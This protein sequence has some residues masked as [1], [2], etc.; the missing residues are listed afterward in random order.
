MYGVYLITRRGRWERY[1]G[2]FRT[3]LDKSR[4]AAMMAS[5]S[6]VTKGC[7]AAFPFAAVGFHWLRFAASVLSLYS[8]LAVQCYF[9]TF[10]I[11]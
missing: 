9:E 1:S 5:R 8:T 10:D 6:A 7:G 4:A 11:K 2:T 3:A